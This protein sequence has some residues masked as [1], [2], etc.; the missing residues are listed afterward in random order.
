MLPQAGSASASRVSSP[1]GRMCHA[2]RRL[3][4]APCSAH[5]PPAWG[6]DAYTPSAYT[7]R[8]VHVWVHVVLNNI[9]NSFLELKISGLKISRSMVDF[10]DEKKLLI[11]FFE[12]F[13]N[14]NSEL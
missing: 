14:V 6:D 4:W 1:A 12:N 2:Y 5:A 8:S 13:Y 3:E 7:G 10:E 11:S 9:S